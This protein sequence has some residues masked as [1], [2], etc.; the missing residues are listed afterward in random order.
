MAYISSIIS[1]IIIIG[2]LILQNYF[3]KKAKQ[4]R[5]LLSDTFPENKDDIS[6]LD[7]EE[8]DCPQICVNESFHENEIFA[9]IRNDINSYLVSNKGSVEYSIIKDITE[10]HCGNI[11]QQVEAITPVPIYIGLCGTV[12]GII[13]GVFLLIWGDGLQ[14]IVDSGVSGIQSLL[15]GVAIAM[16]TTFVGVF[17]TILSSNNTKSSSKEYESE[18]NM[19]LSWVQVN[20]LPQMDGNIISTFTILEKNLNKFNSE[21]AQN[22]FALNR[23]FDG[24]KDS[25]QEQA[26][27]VRTIQRL[28]VNEIAMANIKVLQEL[29]DCTE[30]IHQLQHFIS[31]S[32]QYLSS[33]ESLNKNLSDHY[34]RTKLIENM[35]QFFMS[36]VKQ[37]E[38]RKSAISEAVA[39]IDSSLINAFKGLN[40]HSNNEYN[41]LKNST[42]EQHASFLDAI[43]KQQEALQKKLEETTQIVEELHNLVDVKQSLSDL[44]DAYKVQG[45]QINGLTNIMSNIATSNETQNALMKEMIMGIDKI[46]YESSS[47]TITTIPQ[48]NYTFKLPM[49]FVVSCLITFFVIISTCVL[50]VVK[51]YLQ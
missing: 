5:D 51:T 25:Y 48:T 28:N 10:R 41:E 50:F 22:T 20:L 8:L 29:K 23:V 47:S 14:N 44:L 19:F 36:E 27:L 35:G 15:K 39:E 16:I 21:F 9:K 34:D 17:F 30:Q 31:L 43:H 40:E 38:Q 42:A 7:D 37:I 2:A 4:G 6:L 18:K 3:Y 49:W 24:I 26:E 11:E 32:G 46:S 33:I 45:S 13:I 1:L 12:L